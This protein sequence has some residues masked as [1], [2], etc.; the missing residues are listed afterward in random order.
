M[1]DNIDTVTDSEVWEV[2]GRYLTEDISLAEAAITLS[3]TPETIREILDRYDIEIREPSKEELVE[4]AAACL[5]AQD[6]SD[7]YQYSHSE[8]EQLEEAVSAIIERLNIDL[9]QFRLSEQGLR[10]EIKRSVW[11]AKTTSEVTAE[12]F[13]S[14]MNDIHQHLGTQEWTTYNIVFPLNIEYI[15]V[16]RPDEYGILEETVFAFTSDEWK[17]CCDWA[18]DQ[19][20]ERAEKS[21]AI[22]ARNRLEEW[23]SDSPNQLDRDGQTYWM[24]EI[25]AL[26]QRYAFSKCISALRFLLGRIN[27]ALTHN[28]F[29]GMQFDR[30]VWN[31]RWMDLRLPF[32]YLVFEDNEYS[33]FS[34]GQDPTPRNP[35]RLSSHKADQYNSYFELIPPLNT[36]RDRMES[37]LI[38]S[39]YSFQDAVTNT[40]RE[41]AFLDYWRGAERLTL[42]AETDTTSTVVQRARTVARTSN[43]ISQSEVRDKRNKLVHEGESVEITTDDTNTVKGM[44]EDLICLYV[45]KSSDWMHEDF[46][47]FFE[48]GDKSDAALDALEQDRQT[49]LDMIETIRQMRC[50]RQTNCDR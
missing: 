45:E 29:E 12:A 13:W 2:I 23:F 39:V 14:E 44:L 16:A 24:M 28:R 10:T 33:T 31:T 49:D 48:H 1:F 37:R 21:D 30:S 7:G 36:E 41:D 32:V 3:A 38:K 42:T 5:H 46:L 17:A 25:E 19:E 43:P 4:D 34:H 15:D 35:V 26:D 6:D 18:Y 50:E 8:E 47:F 9:D 11:E 27:F 40:N 20:E 22:N